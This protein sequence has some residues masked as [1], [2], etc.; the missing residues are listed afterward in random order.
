MQG[1]LLQTTLIKGSSGCIGSHQ[2]EGAKMKTI[3][4]CLAWI[5][6]MLVLSLA[7]AYGFWL[8][9]I[10]MLFGY[11]LY[12]WLSVAGVVLLMAAWIWLVRIAEC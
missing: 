7:I 9:L 11:T 1:C 3:L 4:I 2:E 10:F 6:A 8:I 12:M 5:A